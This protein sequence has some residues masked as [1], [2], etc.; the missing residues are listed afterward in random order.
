MPDLQQ[1]PTHKWVALAA[2]LDL[3][4]SEEAS[5]QRVHRQTMFPSENPQRVAACQ[6]LSWAEVETTFVRKP[7]EISALKERK[8]E[9]QD[10]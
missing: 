9:G 4:R 5:Q 10:K 1:G 3:R 6:A 2:L 8:G 7:D